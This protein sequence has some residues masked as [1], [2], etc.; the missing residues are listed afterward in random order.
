LFI[1]F[2][3]IIILSVHKQ[4]LFPAIITSWWWCNW[5]SNMLLIS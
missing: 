2:I 3:I 5:Q 4:Y 1:V